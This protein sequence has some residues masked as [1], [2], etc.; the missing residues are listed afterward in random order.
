MAPRL[1][2]QEKPL[3]CFLRLYGTAKQRML[4][5]CEKFS[6]HHNE[7]AMAGTMKEI[8]RL[9]LHAEEIAPE[10]AKALAEARALGLDPIAILRER[11]AQISNP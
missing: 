5:V 6:S 4:G 8:L 10:V 1:K 3:I 9:E 7:I 11:I 2:K